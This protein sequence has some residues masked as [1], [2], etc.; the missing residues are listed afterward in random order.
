MPN[1]ALMPTSEIKLH[2]LSEGDVRA[3]L[4]QHNP[5]VPAINVRTMATI[6]A[7]VSD[8]LAELP[9]ARRREL[10][11]AKGR[12]RKALF[13]ATSRDTPVEQ[14]RTYFE[15]VGRIER[16]AGRGLG[17]R[18]SLEEGKARLDRYAQMKPLDSWAGPTAGAGEIERQLGIP[19]STLSNWQQRG[20]AIGLLRGERKLAYPLEQ[21]VDA[22][23]V[24]G[25]AGVLEAAPDARAAWLWLRQP[26]GALEGRAPLAALKTSG[27]RDRVVKV[28]ER[29]F[30]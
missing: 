2:S 5:G 9:E 7:I 25:L 3:A 14:N 12:F 22:R 16:S 26:H 29:D 20:A 13:K 27:M 30:G 15:P 19:R 28:A 21:F 4:E 6:L 1:T 18:I 10:A 23:P 24:E 17:E 8:V 11:R